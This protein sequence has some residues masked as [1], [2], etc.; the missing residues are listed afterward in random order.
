[1]IEVRENVFSEIGTDVNWFVVRDGSDLTLID[2]GYPGDVARVEA[3]IRSI[4][5]APEDVRAILLTHAHVDHMGAANHFHDRYGTPI[6]MSETETAHARREYLQQASEL[7][8]A[9]NAWR[10]GVLAWSLRVMRAGATQKIAIPHA[11]AFPTVGALDLPGAPTPV[12]TT[13]HTTGHTAYFLPAAGAVV[14]GDTLVNG[15]PLLRH[16]GPQLLP[17]MFN[18][19]ETDTVAALDQLEGLDADLLLPGHGHP[20]TGSIREAVAKARDV[21]QGRRKSR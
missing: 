5:A 6:L 8:V 3:S 10:P 15:H 2:A 4:G 20:Y 14:T 19:S 16:A 7:D 12:P 21:T 11:E 17:P 1:M 13:G 9:K 18:H